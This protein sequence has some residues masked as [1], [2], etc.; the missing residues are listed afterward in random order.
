MQPG[1]PT[2]SKRPPPPP[3]G[4]THLEDVL[5]GQHEEDGEQPHNGLHVTHKLQHT[6]V[7]P[8]QGISEAAAFCLVWVRP[9]GGG[10]GALS[11]K[12]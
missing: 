2:F 1:A 9:G 5:G 12:A 4:A 11:V 3:P 6:A 10:G 7:Q 8:R